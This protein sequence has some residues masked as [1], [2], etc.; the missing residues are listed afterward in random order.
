ML[1]HDRFTQH[2]FDKI[3]VSVIFFKCV[4]KIKKSKVYVPDAP[5]FFFLC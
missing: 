1:L 5:E 4:L 2:G 3:F